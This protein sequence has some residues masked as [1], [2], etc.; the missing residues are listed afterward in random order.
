MERRHAVALR[1]VRVCAL[2]EQR[3]HRF[4]I[5]SHGGVGD[6]SATRRGGADQRAQAECA[7]QV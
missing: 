6:R 1:G 5:A 3:A 4:A 7:D 2:L